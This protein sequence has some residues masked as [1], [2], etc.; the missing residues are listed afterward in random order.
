LHGLANLIG[1]EQIGEIYPGVRPE[2]VITPG[3]PIDVEKLLL[4]VTRIQFV[5]QLH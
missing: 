2:G 3:S 1:K 5:L 4:I